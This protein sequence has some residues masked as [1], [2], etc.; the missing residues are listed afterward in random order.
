M[1]GKIYVIV[2]L[3]VIDKLESHN[4]SRV[5]LENLS[6]SCGRLTLIHT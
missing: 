5:G 4:I 2:D 6:G 3:F 1:E